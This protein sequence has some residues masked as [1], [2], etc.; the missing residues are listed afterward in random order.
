LIIGCGYYFLAGT[1]STYFLLVGDGEGLD[2][3]DCFFFAGAV[4][5]NYVFLFLLFTVVSSAL[6]S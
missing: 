1:N 6:A 5:I 3:G 4:F 2:S